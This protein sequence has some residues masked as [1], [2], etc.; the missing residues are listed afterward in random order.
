MRIGAFFNA[1]THDDLKKCPRK[2]KKGTFLFVVTAIT[3]LTYKDHR[4]ERG[5]PRTMYHE[6]R[7]LEQSQKKPFI[8]SKIVCFR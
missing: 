3:I 5:T 7:R 4:S 6:T 8:K 1:I 2:V